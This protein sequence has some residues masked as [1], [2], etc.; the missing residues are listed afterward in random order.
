MREL[1]QYIAQAKESLYFS[2][3]KIDAHLQ[4][5]MDAQAGA[6]E[7]L[8]R[9]YKGRIRQIYLVGSGGSLASMQTAKYVLDGLLPVPSEAVG[10]YQLIWREPQLLNKDSFVFFASYSG[11]TEDTVAALRFAKE[12]GAHTV[13]IV[14]QAG[15]T[16]AREAEFVIPYD[17]GAIYEIPV[18]ALIFFAGGQVKGAPADAAL[19]A[20]R[21][22]LLALPDIL[23]RT[24]A[25]EEKLAEGRA[26]ELL[27]A[28]HL[29]VLGSGPLEPLAYKLAMSVVM[30]NLRIG[31]TFSD[32]C[33]WRHGPAE[34]LERLRAQFVVLLGTDASRAMTLRTIDFCRAQGSS[35]LV[36]DAAEFGDVHPLLTPLVMNSHT[37]WLI[38]Y[39]AIL[40]GITDLDERVFMGRNVLATGGAK[41]P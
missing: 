4:S 20:I 2:G 13:A 18:A 21:D 15:S 30:E 9:D 19:C 5:F 23:R 37:Q 35:V 38:A 12:R 39:S 33:E 41:W 6:C 10:S 3:A 14:A 34:A 17:N 26:R 28:Q 36:Y 27:Q 25:L 11:E 32:A 1:Q 8:G 40:R 7:A 31:A 29:Y 24:L 16:M 22:G